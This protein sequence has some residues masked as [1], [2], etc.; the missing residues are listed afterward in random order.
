MINGLTLLLHIILHVVVVQVNGEYHHHFPRHI[1]TF[2][3]GLPFF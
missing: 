3:Y 1:L 2:S